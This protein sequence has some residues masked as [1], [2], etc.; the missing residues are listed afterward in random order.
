MDQGELPVVIVTQ[1]HQLV[2]RRPGKAAAHPHGVLELAPRGPEAAVCPALEGHRLSGGW[3]CLAAS[4]HGRR[5]LSSYWSCTCIS[6]K[7]RYFPPAV[8]MSWAWVPLSIRRSE[9]RRVGK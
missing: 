7:R 8:S 9:E 2:R 1:R 4:D 6:Y 3:A 5:H